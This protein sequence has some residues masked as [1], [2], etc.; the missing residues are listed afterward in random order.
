MLFDENLYVYHEDPKSIEDVCRQKYRHGSGRIMIWKRIPSF[1]FLEERYFAKPLQ[2][3]LD[4]NYV[5]PTHC[6]FLLGYFQTL[7]DGDKYQEFMAFV[8]YVFKKHGKS[9]SDYEIIR[10]MI[11]EYER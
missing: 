2:G 8:E 4:K 7:N 1:E 6:A 5:L 3:G 10:D 11:K 9:L